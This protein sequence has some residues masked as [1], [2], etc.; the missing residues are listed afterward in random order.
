[1]ASEAEIVCKT[2]EMIEDELYVLKLPS[3]LGR[4]I[5][6]NTYLKKRKQH[7]P[8]RLLLFSWQS[9][10]VAYVRKNELQSIKM[11]GAVVTEQRVNNICAGK[12]VCDL[13]LCAAADDVGYF[14]VI[15]C[16]K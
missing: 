7:F 2:T 9:P 3:F 16:F 1:M 13:N 10:S 15:S 14:Y 6:R 5:T 12:G 11:A 8:V 4:D